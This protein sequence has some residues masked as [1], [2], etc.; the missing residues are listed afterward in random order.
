MRQDPGRATGTMPPTA[1]TWDE[2]AVRSYAVTHP[3]G[4]VVLPQPDGWDQ[5][6]HAASGVMT[7]HTADLRWVVPPHR[8]VWVPSGLTHTIEL[9]GRVKLRTLYLRA[10]TVAL[11]GHGARAVNVS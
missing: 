7:V 2:P 5:L 9:A 4:T 10:G 6:V 3:G 11:D 1:P 8:A